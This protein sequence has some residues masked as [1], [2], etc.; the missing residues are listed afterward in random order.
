MGGREPFFP[1]SERGGQ[2][3]LHGPP[4]RQHRGE[5]EVGGMDYGERLG[6]APYRSGFVIPIRYTGVHDDC[7]DHDLPSKN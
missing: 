4:Q 1:E 5:V 2:E 3:G 7:H 6:I